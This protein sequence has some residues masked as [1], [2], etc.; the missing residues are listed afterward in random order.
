MANLVVATLCMARHVLVAACLPLCVVAYAVV[1][2]LG[3]YVLG[4]VEN[5]CNGP[6]QKMCALEVGQCVCACASVSL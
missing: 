6:P 1:R 4:A 3:I 2:A 5:V